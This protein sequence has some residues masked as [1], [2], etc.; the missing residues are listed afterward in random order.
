MPF[1]SR[2][3]FLAASAVVSAAPALAQPPGPNPQPAPK[4]KSPPR[5][6]GA[7]DVIVVGVPVPAGGASPDRAAAGVAIA[8]APEMG[9]R[10]VTDTKISLG[11]LRRAQ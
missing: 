9:G 2:R 5:S 6:D 8:A 4:Q 11:A 7:P 1:F 3:S 10:C